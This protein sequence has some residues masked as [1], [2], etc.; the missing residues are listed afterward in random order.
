MVGQSQGTYS[1]RLLHV[2]EYLHEYLN[3][4]IK[5][6]PRFYQYYSTQAQ[7]NQGGKLTVKGSIY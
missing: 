5:L 3:C 1:G 2:S 7:I 4:A 6:R